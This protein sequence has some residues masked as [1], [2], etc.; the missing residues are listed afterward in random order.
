MHAQADTVNA[1]IEIP[2]GSR[3]KYEYDERTGKLFLDRVLYSSV[4]YPTDYGFIPETRAPD[5]DPLDILVVVHEPTFPGCIV[6]A[7]PIGGL[8]MLDEKGSDF[9]ILAVPT[10]DPRFDTTRELSDLEPHWL[11]EIETFFATYKLL[12]GKPTEVRG[13]HSA[14]EAWQTIAE[15]RVAFRHGRAI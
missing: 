10:G 4:H 13:W 7:R 14:A 15:A 1:L 8:D 2:K 3:N 11:K 5:G 9:K 12:E 6:P